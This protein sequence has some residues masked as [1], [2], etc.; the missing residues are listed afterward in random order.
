MMTAQELANKII[1]MYGPS[2]G[3]VLTPAT[4][5]VVQVGDCT[6]SMLEIYDVVLFSPNASV[7]TPPQVIIQ[8]VKS[9]M[10]S[11]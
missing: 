4:K 2:Y 9:D 6:E 7:D 1:S 3:P 5:V 11:K 8:V 10:T